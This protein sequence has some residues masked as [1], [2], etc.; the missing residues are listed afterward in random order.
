MVCGEE[1][2]KEKLNIIDE[3]WNILGE[4]TREV[5]HKNGLLHRE[6]H[7]WLFNKKGEILFQRRGPRK[8]TFPNLLDAT[9]GGHV[10]LGE[11]YL[12]AAIREL[13]EELNLNIN[14][15]NLILLGDYK[16]KTYD[17]VTKNTNNVI[18][19]IYSYKFEGNVQDLKLEKGEVVSL[20]FWSIEKLSN[21]T[22]KER[23]EFCPTLLSEEYLS[24]LEKIKLTNEKKK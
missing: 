18:K 19:K 9:A 20:E 3:Q 21:I 23:K 17:N 5:I 1:K 10:D 13:K 11:D 4:E 8:D 24:L 14:S 6:L 16:S 22:E 2:M 15:S 12:S 7:V